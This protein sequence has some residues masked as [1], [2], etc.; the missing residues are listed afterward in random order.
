MYLFILSLTYW[1]FAAFNANAEP[2]MGDASAA[3]PHLTAIE[4]NPGTAAFLDRSQIAISPE[5]FKSETLYARYPGFESASLSE[6]GVGNILSKPQFIYKLNSRLALGGYA[7]PPLGVE[8]DIKKERLPVVLLGTLNYVDLIAKGRL[9]GAGQALLAYRVSS[10][11]GVG[12][13]ATF[14][15]VGFTAELLPSDGGSK[16][17]DITGDITKVSSIVGMRYEI[18]SGLAVGLSF[19][20]F[21]QNN[22][23]LQIDSPLLNQGAGGGEQPGGNSGSGG[24]SVTNPADS[25]LVGVE[26]SPSEKLRMLLDLKYTRANTEQETFSLVDL[27]NKK[28]DVYDTLAV[29]AGMSLAVTPTSFGLLGFRYEP[30]NIGPGSPGED[31]TSGF[32]TI[33]LVSIFAGF[34][35][36]K[37][38][39]QYS[40]GLKMLA[41]WVAE[42]SSKKKGAEPRGFHQWEVSF[43][44]VHRIASLGI[45]E[46]GELPG[47]YLH[48]KTF[49][50]VTVLRK[51]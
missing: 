8:I 13:N 20:L 21:S 22:Q 12:V 17:A 4:D 49:I 16:L 7:I 9:N 45:D 6:N 30:S 24:G 32:G 38:Y 35:T 36:L 23:D 3:N 19:G 25:F 15:S 41:G 40:L 18:S 11:F 43:G 42:R 37:P 47:A 34:D 14:E 29:R 44:L 50:P 31:G 1:M 51:F 26:A 10:G 48:K 28:R 33:D 46:N 2:L 39:T 5:V 27:K